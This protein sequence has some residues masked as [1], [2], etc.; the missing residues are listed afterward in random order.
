[1]AE[2]IN[3]G[4]YANMMI[5]KS[6]NALAENEVFLNIDNFVDYPVEIAKICL[7]DHI[8]KNNIDNILKGKTKTE[9]ILYLTKNNLK[10]EDMVKYS[11]SFELIYKSK[12][13]KAL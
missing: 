11:R 13:L 5:I 10:F 2:Q 4:Q 6:Y 9:A 8:E 3:L 7:N 12:T 1:M